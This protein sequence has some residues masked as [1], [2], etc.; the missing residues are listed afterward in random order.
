[1]TIDL[2]IPISRAVTILIIVALVSFW[3]V[4]G[5]SL[6]D[7]RPNLALAAALAGLFFVNRLDGAVLV[8]VASLILKFAP[9]YNLE[10]LIFSLLGFT[11]VFLKNYLP[12]QNIFNAPALVVVATILFYLILAPQLLMTP[13]FVKELILNTAAGVICFLVFSQLLRSLHM[14]GEE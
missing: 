7:V 1:M 8:A 12:W 11:A 6:F 9:G 4:S 2:P 3:Q 13:L 10:I 5:F 14:K